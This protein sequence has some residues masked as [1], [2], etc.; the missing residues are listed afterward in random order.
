MADT[1]TDGVFTVASVHGP[2]R[3]IA[4]FPH[5][6]A[7][8][9]LEQDYLINFDNFTP[10]ALNTAHPTLTSYK[11]VLES[12]L[13]PFG[14]GVTKFTRTFAQV[15]DSWSDSSGNYAYNFIGF[16]GA[17]GINITDITGRDRF[18]RTVPVRIYREYF[19]VGSGGSYSDFTDIPLNAEQKYYANGVT[20]LE[21]NWLADSPPFSIATSPTRTAYEALITGEDEIVVETSTRVRWMGNIWCRETRYVQAQ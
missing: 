10:L 8:Y 7:R 16:Y 4:P 2:A 15:P 9:V 17:W 20:N 13:D 18:T 5:T 6:S 19:M 1:L 21:T 14:C 3:L 12:P 11:L